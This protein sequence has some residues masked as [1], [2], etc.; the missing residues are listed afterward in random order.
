MNN[1]R[2]RQENLR[3]SELMIILEVKSNFISNLRLLFWNHVTDSPIVFEI[4]RPSGGQLITALNVSY[5]CRVGGPSTV[6]SPGNDVR[7]AQHE[8]FPLLPCRD[9]CWV[10]RLF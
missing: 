6:A 10:P 7:G 1:R 2:G 5:T 3:N 8:F 9:F 4:W